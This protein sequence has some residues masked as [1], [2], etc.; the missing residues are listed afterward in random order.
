MEKYNEFRD[1]GLPWVEKIPKGWKLVK[2]KYVLKE[3]IEKNN[4]MKTENILS[5]T[6]KQGV[7]PYDQ[8]EGGGNKPKEDVTNYKLAYPGDIVINSMNILSGSTGLSHYFGCVSPVY[9]MLYPYDGD[10]IG[11]ASCRERVY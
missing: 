3:R 11:R 5:L 4:P 7:V 9:Y 8:K 2:I 6:A 1:T 10:E